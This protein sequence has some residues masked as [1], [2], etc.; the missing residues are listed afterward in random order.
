MHTVCNLCSSRWEA[1][2]L[3]PWPFSYHFFSSCVF[4]LIGSER[5]LL[6]SFVLRS[7]GAR[8][9]CGS[10]VPLRWHPPRWL[11]LQERRKDESPG[12]VSVPRPW[13]HLGHGSCRW[14]LGVNGAFLRWQE[15]SQRN[16]PFEC[17]CGRLCHFSQ[18]GQ[19]LV[20]FFTNAWPKKFGS[21]WHAT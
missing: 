4:M 8:G 2:S 5:P 18:Q 6:L 3:V 9:H 19:T 1:H 10:F 11:V 17:G 13:Q 12:R 7:R 16:V 15:Q 20:S 21:V 14:L